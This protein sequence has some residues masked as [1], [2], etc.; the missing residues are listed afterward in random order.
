MGAKSWPHLV[1][2]SQAR[3]EPQLAPETDRA[4]RGQKNVG[5]TQEELVDR[6][7]AGTDVVFH[8]G[9]I[10][11]QLHQFVDLQN[12]AER[13]EQTVLLHLAVAQDDFAAA[14]EPFIT[15]EAVARVSSW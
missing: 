6:D 15:C 11:V 3:I 4:V 1:V 12:L 5:R 9:L 13:D 2:Q 10:E 14:I 7:D 8:L